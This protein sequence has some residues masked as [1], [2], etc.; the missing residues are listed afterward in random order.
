[1][2]YA[3]N[4]TLRQYLSKNFNKMNWDLKLKFA[5]QISSA[6]F[7]F[8][9]NNIIHRDLV[10][11]LLFSFTF[12]FNKNINQLLFLLYNLKKAS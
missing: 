4:G 2:E 8:H 5:K 10:S 7:C 3:D 6:V 12:I 1:M 9:E 11:L